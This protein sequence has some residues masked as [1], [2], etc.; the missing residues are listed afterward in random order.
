MKKS[1]PLKVMGITLAALLSLS[2]VSLTG[3]SQKSSAGGTS[4]SG[5]PSGSI[6]VAAWNDAADAMKAEAKEFMAENPGTTVTV[7]SVDSNYTKLYPEL[8]AG[9][10]VPDVVQTQNRDF[11]SFYNKYPN[12]WL[13]VT[14]LVQPAEKDFASVVLPLVSTKGKYYAVPWDLGPCALYYRTDVFKADGIDPSSLKTWDDYITAGETVTKDSG[15]KEKVMG[16]DYSGSSSQDMEN[17]LFNEAG[18]KFYDSNGKVQLDTPQMI[19]M[20]TLVKKMMSAG[21]TMNLAN[22]W[23]DRI[24]A[25]EN[26]ELVAFPYAVWYT[27]T[28][29]SSNSDQSGKWGIVPLP[30]Y[31]AGGN[32]EANE[33]GS[34]LA[35]SSQT[36]NASLAKAFVKFSLMTDK[37]NEINLTAGGLF[38]SYM[39]SYKDSVYTAQDT[40]YTGLS[41][42]KTFSALSSK[43]PSITY[44]PY[45]TDVNNA[46][47]TAIGEILTKNADMKSTLDSA[48][49]T[50]QKA[51]DNE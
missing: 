44:G 37:G 34:I 35:I 4:S 29:K 6:T 24:T 14:D 16:L 26:N 5:K 31:T 15:G 32:N 38:T 18:G 30:A 21:V 41:I 47:T 39:P 2:A 43:I 20:L 28:M 33:G 51:I 22:E 50:A 23:D 17:L 25:Q 10:G 46:Y 9:S 27:G 12:A 3:C 19:Q 13:D 48:T 11:M 45:Y 40:Y 8:A 49:A 36:K 7:Q 1:T 42:G